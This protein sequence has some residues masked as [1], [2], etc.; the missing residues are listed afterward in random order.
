MLR[1]KLLAYN[2]PI[3]C[4]PLVSNKGYRVKTGRE[5]SKTVDVWS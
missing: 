1:D 4:N 3:N 5:W 2:K